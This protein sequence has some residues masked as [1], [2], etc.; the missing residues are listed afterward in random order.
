MTAA[1]E[2][3]S[4]AALFYNGSKV[5]STAAPQ[6]F[7]SQRQHFFRPQHWVNG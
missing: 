6:H 5:F 1:R 7:V 3:S 2:N 4:T